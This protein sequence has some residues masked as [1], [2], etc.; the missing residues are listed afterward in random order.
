MAGNNGPGYWISMPQIPIT[1]DDGQTEYHDILYVTPP[2]RE[3]LRSQIMA[4]L[5]AQGHIKGQSKPKRPP[6]HRTPEAIY[7]LRSITMCLM[8]PYIR[9]ICKCMELKNEPQIKKIL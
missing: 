1:G 5:Q 7:V 9:E 2:A 3:H 4:E 8:I 6:P